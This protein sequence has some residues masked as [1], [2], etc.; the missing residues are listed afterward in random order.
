MGKSLADHRPTHSAGI[1]PLRQR[2]STLG[3][4]FSLLTGNR[5][6]EVKHDKAGDCSGPP[7][8]LFR[9]RKRPLRI[10][11]EPLLMVQIRWY[12][13]QRPP[14]APQIPCQRPELLGST[15]DIENGREKTTGAADFF[16]AKR[17]PLC[18]CIALA[19]TSCRALWVSG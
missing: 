5:E 14:N 18:F 7:Y 6:L 16:L 2:K 11:R 8:V 4:N 12:S 15:W 17:R 1:T 3:Y 19:S 9:S 10:R 13:L